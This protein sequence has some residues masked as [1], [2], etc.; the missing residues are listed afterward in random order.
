MRTIIWRIKEGILRRIMMRGLRLMI[1]IKRRIRI[2]VRGIM[3]IILR[4]I[5]RGTMA[6]IYKENNKYQSEIKVQPYPD[7]LEQNM[8]IIYKETDKY[9]IVSQE[10]IF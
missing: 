1:R 7:V 3:W 8:V 4:R 6:I 10:A 5:I 9:T 2:I